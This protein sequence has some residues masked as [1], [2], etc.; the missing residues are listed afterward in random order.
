MIRRLVKRGLLLGT[1]VVDL[2]AA[3]AILRPS[4]DLPQFDPSGVFG[5]PDAPE[6][7][8]AALGDSSVTAPGVGGP[9]EI[10]I[11]LVAERLAIT[12]HVVLQSFAVG[13]SMAHNLVAEQMDEA[14]LFGPDLVFVSVGANDAIKGVSLRKFAENLDR[15][16]A[17]L[18]DTGAVVVH[19]GV[20]D[21]G[22]IPRLYPPLSTMMTR[23]SDR[24]DKAHWEIAARH[25]TTVVPHRS[26]ERALWTDDLAL[27]SSDL[28]HVSAA[29]HK[30]WAELTW[31]TVQPL[32]ENV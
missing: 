3:Y 27:W 30:R 32:L 11:T 6:L 9:E 24:F 7:R 2:E 17:E 15:L 22:T 18:S 14:I 25:G 31:Q 13:G 29:G 28:F 12:H 19:S 1:T 23:R 8:V 20:G 16:I 5:S 10:W 21:L 26:D 4:P